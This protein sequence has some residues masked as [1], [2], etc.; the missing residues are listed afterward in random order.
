MLFT[1]DRE[2]NPPSFYEKEKEQ[3]DVVICFYC[4]ETVKMENIKTTI[5]NN[6]HTPIY[7]CLECIKLQEENGRSN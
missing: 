5:I 3:E 4:F 6:H 1:P 7:V 2:I